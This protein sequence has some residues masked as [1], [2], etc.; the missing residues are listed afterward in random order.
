MIKKNLDKLNYKK[1][2]GSWYGINPVTRCKGDDK[3][4]LDKEICRLTK[5]DEDDNNE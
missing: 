3:K 4:R 1:Q 2:R 5:K